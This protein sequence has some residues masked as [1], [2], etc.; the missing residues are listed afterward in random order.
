MFVYMFG[1]WLCSYSILVKL[2]QLLMLLLV[3]MCSCLMFMCLL[4]QLICVVVCWFIQI[5]YGCSGCM[6]LL[7]G[8]FE[9]LYRLFMYIVWIVLVGMFCVC[10]LFMQLL[11]QLS[12]V[13]NYMCGYC[14]VY[15]GCGVLGWQLVECCVM[16][17]L[18]W[19]I[20]SV[21]VFCVLMLMFMMYFMMF[22]VRCMLVVSG[23][24][25]VVF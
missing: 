13:L 23:L 9:L 1:C 21:L 8:M 17:V 25:L 15:S 19:L 12:I 10:V 6:L 4:I 16:I 11:M 3:I 24:V 14:L 18:C 2:Q 5:R 22:L 7:I 20:S